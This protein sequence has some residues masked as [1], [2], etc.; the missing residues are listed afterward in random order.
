MFQK[1]GSNIWIAKL[2]GKQKY[3]LHNFDNFGSKY[4]KF[5][6]HKTITI[7]ACTP[8]SY[9]TEYLPSYGIDMMYS[10]TTIDLSFA[11]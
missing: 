3:T 7:A 10:I 9:I 1:F 2:L 5:M 8:Q 4:L 6:I 11:I